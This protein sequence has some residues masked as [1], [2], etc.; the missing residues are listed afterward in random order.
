MLL[1][2]ELLNSLVRDVGSERAFFLKLF[3]RGSLE[4]FFRS[5]KEASC[6][7]TRGKTFLPKKSFSTTNPPPG[8]EPSVFRAILVNWFE[9]P[10]Y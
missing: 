6:P 2:E 3:S 8:F 4:A 9:R 5:G 1:R 7:T 10:I